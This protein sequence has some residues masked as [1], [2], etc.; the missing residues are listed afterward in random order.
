MNAN[1]FVLAT[2]ASG[3]FLTVA[4]C[5]KTANTETAEA[6]P[7][8]AQQA[9]APQQSKSG[10]GGERVQSTAAS[11]QNANTASAAPAVPKVK[12]V[13]LPG[14][15]FMTKRV[16][17]MT[18]DGVVA[19]T[20]GTQVRLV[21]QPGKKMT[22]ETSQGKFQ[23]TSDQ[24]TTDPD[25]AAQLSANEAQS[26]AAIAAAQAQTR[27]QQPAPQSAAVAAAPA[28]PAP[29]PAA[30]VAPAAPSQLQGT[31][32]DQPTHDAAHRQGHWRRL[33]TG[34]WQWIPGS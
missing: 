15:Y 26:Q 23:V 7:E 27:A 3:I 28:I 29:Q 14:V 18:D 17:K 11:A 31:S 32:L 24:V 13:A 33:T 16:S 20:P 8:Q 1:Q 22:V 19:L 10:T 4:G 2:L 34:G 5:N 6:P 21:G 9:S 30:A 25:L 12:R